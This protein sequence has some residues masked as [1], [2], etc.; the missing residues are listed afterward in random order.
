M[1]RIL[2][3]CSL[4][5]GG[6]GLVQAD[7]PRPNVIVIL[8]DDLGYADVGFHDI[9]AEDG[10][11]TPH[12]DQLAASGVVFTEAYASS[13]ICSAS[14]LALS[15]GRYQQRW[16]AYHYGQGGL[17]NEEQTIAEMMRESGYR[18]MKVGKTHLNNGPKQDPMKHGFDGYLGFEHH[19][20][21][22]EL[23]S[24]KDV[25]A[26]NRKKAGSA[27]MTRMA[28]IGP[29]NRDSKTTESFED[30]TTTE[31]FAEESIR[32]IEEESDRP[33]YLQ[34]EFNAVHTPLIRGPK[35]LREKY[36]IPDRPFDRNAA[37]WEYPLWDPVAQPDYKAWYSETCHL[38]ISDP[39]GRQIYLAHLE[40]M[41]LMIGQ[42]ME[43][44]EAQG[45]TEDTLI[46]FSSDNGG[47]HQSYA[48]NGPLHAFKYCLMDGGIKVPMV[49]SWPGKIAKGTRVDAMVT[50][51]DLFPSLSEII[52][53]APKAPLDGKNLMPLI[54]G[55]V[56]LLHA[57][58]VFWDS[59]NK[60]VNWVVRDGDW[61]L[62]YR[63]EA[64]DYEIYELGADGL[65][66]EEFRIEAI[67]TGMQLYHLGEDPG[68]TENLA[69]KNPERVQAMEKVYQEWRSEMGEPVSGKKV[70]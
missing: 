58:P 19:S 41:D 29:L 23:L 28:P 24:D 18:T 66:K 1:K 61:K 32:F 8:A 51:R 69:S 59:G 31:V 34:L 21:D 45:L 2:S 9:V 27:E 13:P 68:E 30:T 40:L 48:N 15:T 70:Q 36:G 44:V 3:L 37:V 52:G 38:V 26:Y 6:I 57:E 67:P 63:E 46:F 60:M 39:Y 53:I 54:A 11:T 16:G 47:S 64:R 35:Q 49:M 65:V 4:V 62:V 55:E 20:W 33:F 25:A 50:H 12:L 17:P 43:A 7:A 42:I 14:R 5:V 22:F 10:V 56:E